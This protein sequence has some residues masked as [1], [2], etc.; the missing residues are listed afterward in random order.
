MS[1]VSAVFRGVELGKELVFENQGASLVYPGSF[2]HPGKEMSL[3]IR[4]TE[5]PVIIQK[6][7]CEHT[8][9][10]PVTL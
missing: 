9:E 4:L 7:A 1:R 5:Q 10:L 6:S 3:G 8:A 2:S